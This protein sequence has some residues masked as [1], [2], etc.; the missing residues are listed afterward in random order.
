MIVFEAY[1][2]VGDTISDKRAVDLC[3]VSQ[4]QV[5]C[6]CLVAR[7]FDDADFAGPRLGCDVA[8]AVQRGNLIV[9]VDVT[10]SVHFMPCQ[11]QDDVQIFVGCA[12]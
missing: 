10:D 1:I 8:A 4:Q 2:Q 12:C 6:G 5:W 9:D 3:A 11:R 7:V